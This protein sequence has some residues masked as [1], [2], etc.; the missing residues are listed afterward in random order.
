[1]PAS[2]P[3][4]FS[5]LKALDPLHEKEEDGEYHDRE[6]YIEHIGH[7]VSFDASVGLP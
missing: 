5:A 7:G 4:Q 3:S 2:R 1:M 6:R